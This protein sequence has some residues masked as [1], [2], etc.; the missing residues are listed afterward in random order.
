[1]VEAALGRYGYEPALRAIEQKLVGTGARQSDFSW[2]TRQAA[3]TRS[4]RLIPALCAHLGDKSSDFGDY[5]VAPAADA[6]AALDEIRRA[7]A[8]MAPA[9]LACPVR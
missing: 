3:F 6:A 9:A 4:P 2:T 8:T 5:V 7:N 1:M